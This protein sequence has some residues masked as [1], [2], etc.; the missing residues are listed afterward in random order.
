M[1]RFFS[2]LPVKRKLV[3]LSLTSAVLLPVFLY[4]LGWPTLTSAATLRRVERQYLAPPGA[5]VAQGDISPEFRDDDLRGNHWILTQNEDGGYAVATLERLWGFLW[6]DARYLQYTVPGRFRQPEQVLQPVSLAC[7]SGVSPD[8]TDFVYYQSLLVLSSDDAVA[9]V[10]ATSAALVAEKQHD[11]AAYI[12][13]DGATADC[14]QVAPG[15]WYAEMMFPQLSIFGPSNISSA[16]WT[17]LRG[18]AADGK[19]LYEYIPEPRAKE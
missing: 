2:R 17:I 5:I 13:N 9:R 14:V 1:R 15:V 3:L 16:P 19:L 18:Y 7:H 6:R 8:Q 4:L 11:P 10:T 12:D